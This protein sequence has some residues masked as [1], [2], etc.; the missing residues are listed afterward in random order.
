MP[1]LNC[2]TG[3]LGSSL[4]LPSPV[5]TKEPRGGSGAFVGDAGVPKPVKSASGIRFGRAA[6][7]SGGR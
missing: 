2:R 5:R 4:A 6:R 3:R 7:Q 1:S